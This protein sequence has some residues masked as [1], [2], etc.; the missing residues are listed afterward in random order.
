MVKPDVSF[1]SLINSTFHGDKWPMSKWYKLLKPILQKFRTSRALLIKSHFED[2]E[3]FKVLDLGGSIHFWQEVGHILKPKQLVILNIAADHQSVGSNASISDHEAIVLYDGKKIPFGDKEFDL[4]ICN[5]VM[6]HV[7]PSE[8]AGLAAEIDRVAKR[9][10][11]QT[12][13]QSFPIEPHFV[14]PI[15]HWVPRS[16]GRMMS[17]LTPLSLFNGPGYARSMFDEVVLLNEKEMRQLFPKSNIVREKSMGMTKSY[18]A[19]SG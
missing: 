17:T 19:F 8:R 18:M 12:P 14:S 16:I 11:V 3:N 2:I 6:E 1:K 9:F 7:P 15:V 5:S 10:V 13:A 4:V